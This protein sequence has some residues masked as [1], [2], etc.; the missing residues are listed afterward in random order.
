MNNPDAEKPML[1]PTAATP[2]ASETPLM[3]TSDEALRGIDYAMDWKNTKPSA[4]Q[5]ATGLGFARQWI[6]DAAR[7]ITELRADLAALRAQIEALTG[8][9]ERWKEFIE[10]C[11]VAEDRG[12]LDGDSAETVLNHINEAAEEL[13]E[14]AKKQALAATAPDAGK[15]AT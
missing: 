13:L 11:A 14:A 1:D 10:E 6:I 15:G 9:R 12:N 8:E 3:N 7:E 5:F 2:Q 4:V